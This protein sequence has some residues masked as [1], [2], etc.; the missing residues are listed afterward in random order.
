MQ[1]DPAGTHLDARVDAGCVFRP[2][3][4]AKHA[5]TRG[6]LVEVPHPGVIA[7]GEGGKAA[8]KR[9]VHAELLVRLANRGLL[10]RLARLDATAREAV[11][12]LAVITAPHQRHRAI[13]NEDDATVEPHT[14]SYYMWLPRAIQAAPDRSPPG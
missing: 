11:E 9:D 14:A 5:A 7:V 6:C 8:S 2:G 4:R 3:S 12:L 1:R 13:L 10:E